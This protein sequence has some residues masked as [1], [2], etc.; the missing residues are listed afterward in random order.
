MKFLK[1]FYLKAMIYQSRHKMLLIFAG[2]SELPKF[3]A[4]ISCLNPDFL[5][6]ESGN[7]QNSLLWFFPLV[8]S[9]Q[10]CAKSQSWT[11]RWKFG[12]NSLSNGPRGVVPCACFQIYH[13]IKLKNLTWHHIDFSPN[14][15][16][17]NVNEN[18]NPEKN[19]GNLELLEMLL[20]LCFKNF[21][22]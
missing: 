13:L 15:L 12:Q 11:F 8:P 17:S 5:S 19:G 14:F 22:F 1:I 4:A 18:L 20:L 10:I 16:F 2:V 3:W 6:Y 7:I 9:S 21:G